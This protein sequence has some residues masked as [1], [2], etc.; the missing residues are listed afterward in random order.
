MRTTVPPRM[1][2]KLRIA[3]FVAACILLY[4]GRAL[5]A[6][7]QVSA[8]AAAVMEQSSHRILY[9]KN[10]HERLPMASTTKI[11]TALVAIEN[12][13]LGDIV[14]VSEKASRIPGS[15]IYLKAGERLTL[16]QLLYGLMLQSGNDAAMAIAE[17]IGGSAAGFIDMMNAKA[18]A[19]GAQ[20]TRFASTSGLDTPGHYTTA[21]DLALI[22][23]AAM[24]SDVFRRIV[25]TK[26]IRI[27]YDG[28]DNGRIV[29]NKNDTLWSFDGAN[30]VKTGYT[31][32][33]GRCFVGAAQREGMQLVAVVLNC[34]PMFEESSLLL[35]DAF[36]RYDM[37]DVTQA[38]KAIGAVSVADGVSGTVRYGAME[39]LSLPLSAE[40]RQRI[41]TEYNLNPAVQ[42]PITACQPLGMA[43]V[44]LDGTVLAEY[45]VVSLESDGNRDYLWWL[46]QV[47]KGAVWRTDKGGPGYRSF[48]LPG[49]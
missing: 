24:E 6:P 7:P 1:S 40:E 26:S 25:S 2:C 15:S 9:E 31:S 22:A 30:G 23:S 13:K 42:A 37:V 32:K 28:I 21:C 11:M 46:H 5:A 45:P 27:P 12:G 14:T 18:Q 10:G 39:S 38:R 36:K 8:R 17:H 44:T 29:R 3:L 20:D 41:C 48:L 16:E 43:R 4:N 33:A 47:I 19:L 49:E 35:D 34:G